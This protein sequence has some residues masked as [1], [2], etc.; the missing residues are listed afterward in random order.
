V[1]RYET[2][3]NRTKKA[4]E[5]GKADCG[6]GAAGSSGCDVLDVDARP[7][8]RA[9][10]KCPDRR[11]A[12]GLVAAGRYP[13]SV[14]ERDAGALSLPGPVPVPIVFD[15][16]VLV[17]AVAAGESPFRSWPSPPVSGNP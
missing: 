5:R 9:G 3:L 1:Q 14:Q 15:V 4:E 6:C 17:L 16:N 11:P 7:G 8:V 13:P 12:P 2:N 10:G